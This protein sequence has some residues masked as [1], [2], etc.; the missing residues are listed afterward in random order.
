MCAIRSRPAWRQL[1]WAGALFVLVA[2][3]EAD[4]P[5]EEADPPPILPAQVETSIAPAAPVAAAD[6]PAVAQESAVGES[7]EAE[8]SRRLATAQ[9]YFERARA[10]A[11]ERHRLQSQRCQ[12][13]GL[14]GADACIASADEALQAELRAARVEFDAQMMQLN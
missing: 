11:E 3:R 5:A 8:Q 13:H 1:V 12:E 6:L 14:A 7:A 2:C 4:Q 9:S 10:D